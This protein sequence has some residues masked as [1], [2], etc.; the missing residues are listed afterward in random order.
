[1]QI[2]TEKQAFYPL[3]DAKAPELFFSQPVISQN[4]PSLPA[5]K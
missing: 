4:A 2:E 3:P 5:A 1:M